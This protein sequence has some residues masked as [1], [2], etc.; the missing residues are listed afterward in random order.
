MSLSSSWRERGAVAGAGQLAPRTARSRRGRPRA[1]TAPRRTPARRPRAPRRARPSSSCACPRAAPSPC[2]PAGARARSA[3]RPRASGRR[4]SARHRRARRGSRGEL[5]PAAH[6]RLPLARHRRQRAD[7]RAHVAGALGVVRLGD[8]QVAREALRA[9]GV[10]G[11]EVR[12]GDPEAARVA[13]DVVEREQAAVA[14]EGG[15]LDAL[16]HDRRRGLLEARDERLR[17]ARDPRGQPRLLEHLDVLGRGLA[18]DV[19]AVD[20]QRGERLRHA[21]DARPLAREPLGLGR[22]RRPRLL[23]LGLVRVGG[24]RPR[25]AGDLLPQRGQRRL[26]R[27][28]DE[29]RRDVVEELVA[30]RAVDRP[31]AQLLAGVDDL[32]DPDVTHAVV[33]QPPQVAGRVG[34]P[35][36][37]VDPQAVDD[38]GADERERQRVRL[39]EHRRVL[40]AHGGEVVDVEEAPVAAGLGVDV[41]EA[42]AQ[43]RVRPVAV[44]VVGRHVVGDDV[45]DQ[46]HPGLARPRR[47]APRTPRRRPA[48]SRSRSGRRRRSRAWSPPAPGRTAA[49]RGG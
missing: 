30:D 12:D 25:V 22:E 48:R 14:V 13:A 33:A 29:Q 16:G 8:E 44:G 20:G 47:R 21:L 42:L 49:G 32:L 27:R 38:A 36:R 3:R 35:V 31:G 11:V 41:E 19:G 17:G 39:L 43:L 45:E 24:E 15:V 37:M 2:T 5:E 23:E 28:V 34:E 40:L 10:G 7:P 46:P 18:G 4:S 6:V 1:R 9:L 26:A